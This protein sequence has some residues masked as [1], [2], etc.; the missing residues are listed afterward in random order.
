MGKATKSSVSD[1]IPQLQELVDDFNRRIRRLSETAS[2]GGEQI[3]ES[4]SEAKEYVRRT[5]EDIMT[6]V[7]E[8]A[9]AVGA[10]PMVG[11]VS[12]LSGDAAGRVAS[13]AG[14]RPWTVLAAA[15][16]LGFLIGFASRR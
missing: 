13:E 10:T 16:G 9:A 11:E 7:R 3:A 4:S 1:E 12:R 14:R 15:A 8:T 5:L 6:R 2:A